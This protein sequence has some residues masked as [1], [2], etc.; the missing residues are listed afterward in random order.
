S[1]ARQLR[2]PP[3]GRPGPERKKSCSRLHTPFA[4]VHHLF[5]GRDDVEIG[6]AAADVAAHQLADLVSRP[7]TAFFYQADGR[8]DLPRSAVPALE[9]IVIDERL[10]NRMKRA[11]FRE[12][13]DRRHRSAVLHD[14]QRQA[15][16]DAAAINQDGAG[17]ALTVIAAFFRA[18]E[19]EV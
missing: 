13:F 7:C 16:I 15:G 1:D 3:T 4:R 5:N 18:G 11:L 10:L 6:A 19:T 2:G 8:T 9:R 17:A 12:P 14:R